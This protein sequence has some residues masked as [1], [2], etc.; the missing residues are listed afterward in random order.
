MSVL[1]RLLEIA[2]AL[3][4][5]ILVLSPWVV[6]VKLQ[7]L[8]KYQK[9]EHDKTSGLL[10][11]QVTT[12]QGRV[13]QLLNRIQSQDLPTF[14]AL[15]NLTSVTSETLVTSDGYVDSSDEA[16]LQRYLHGIGETNND[17]IS[18]ELREL[19]SD[20]GHSGIDSDTSTIP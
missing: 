8:L 12:E 16:E 11:T 6:V 19:R 18:D 5:V 4:I 14:A 9:E 13:Q 2:G 10:R 7:Q 17:G 20:F 3:V 15:Q 1:L